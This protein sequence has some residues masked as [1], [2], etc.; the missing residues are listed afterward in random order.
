MQVVL[1]LFLFEFLK[2]GG[3]D[4]VSLWNKHLVPAVV[5]CFISSDQ[6][7]CYAA[8]VE[9]IQDS[10]RAA[11]VLAAKLVRILIGR[12]FRRYRLVAS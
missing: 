8:R 3:I 10:V 2:V 7:K 1:F 11:F 12:T 5:A 4:R 9:G 6:Q